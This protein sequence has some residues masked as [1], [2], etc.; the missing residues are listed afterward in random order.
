M[1]S[2]VKLLPFDGKYI[3]RPQLFDMNQR[4]L[5]IAEDQML[6]GGDGKE[7]IVRKHFSK[8][9]VG[10]GTG[11]GVVSLFKLYIAGIYI[12]D[13]DAER[14]EHGKNFFDR[15]PVVFK[16]FTLLLFPIAPDFR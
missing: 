13:V 12:S 16:V 11:M 3:F 1:G 2:F 6:Q 14:F 7:L 5:S 8:S 10:T 9:E 4:A 15:Q